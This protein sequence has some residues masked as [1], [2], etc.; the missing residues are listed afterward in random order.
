MHGPIE[1]FELFSQHF[2]FSLPA[3]VNFV[4]GGG[5]TSLI[6]K[7]L[8]EYSESVPVIYTTTTRIH[9]PHPCDGLAIISSDND[10]YLE[11]ML[12]NAVLGWC[13]GRRF[14]VTHLSSGPGLLRGVGRDFADRL[15]RALFPLILN[16]ADGARSMPLK[17]PREGEPV[18]MAGANYLVPVIGLDCLNRPLGPQTLFRWELASQRYNLKAGQILVP[19]LAASILLHPQ[20]VCK[21]WQPGMQIIPFINKVDSDSEDVPARALARALMNN[22]H[23]PVQRVVWGSVHNGSAASLSDAGDGPG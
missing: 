4:G 19:E 5:K 2:A 20:G 6:L 3:R 16:E 11:M 18:L 10:S 8:E 7:L 17:M 13:C 23:F 14:V 9:P 12:E 21:D 1:D 22:D 15:D